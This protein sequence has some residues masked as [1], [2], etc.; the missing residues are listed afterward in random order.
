MENLPADVAYA[1]NAASN[2]HVFLLAKS[3]GKSE[4]S[5]NNVGI[6]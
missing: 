6:T 5:E 3:I 1:M 2:K 4:I